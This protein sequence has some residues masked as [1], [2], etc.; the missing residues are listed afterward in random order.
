MTYVGL[1]VGIHSIHGT[2]EEI[3]E[4]VRS[5]LKL[6]FKERRFDSDIDVDIEESAGQTEIVKKPTS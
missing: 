5:A 2:P 4:R 1:S 3:R 6:E